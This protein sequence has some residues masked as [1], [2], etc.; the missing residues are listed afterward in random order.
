MLNGDASVKLWSSSKV[1][2]NIFSLDLDMCTVG[3]I[4]SQE[5]MDLVV[6]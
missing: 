6:W 4:G 1:A 5:S 2:E 3:G